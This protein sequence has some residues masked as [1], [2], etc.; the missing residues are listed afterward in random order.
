[1]S[2]F[3]LPTLFIL[4]TSNTLP[5]TGSTADLTAAQFGVFKPDF[6]PATAAN[7]AAQPYVYLAQGR[8]ESLPGVGSK[9][10]DKIYL[11]NVRDWYKMTAH[12]T[13]QVQIT[14]IGNFNILCGETITVSL[15]LTSFYIRTGFFNGLTRSYTVQAPCC[16]CGT[17]PCTELDPTA[18]V[19][20][21]V[22]KIN[23]DVLVSQF[24]FA[25]RT[26]TGTN[27]VLSLVGIPLAKDGTRC[28]PS[29]F[30]YEYDRMD[31]W[32]FCYAGPETTQ[33][34]NVWDNCNQAATVT[35]L[36]RA[37]FLS[38]ESGQ[39][40]QVE[41]NLWSYNQGAQGKELFKWDIFNNANPNTVSYV[42]AG[43]FYDQYYLKFDSPENI[44]WSMGVP[45]DEE[46]LI[47][48]PTGQ[49]AG[50]I[51]VLTAFFGTPVDETGNN[52]TTTTSTSTSTTSTSSTTTIFIP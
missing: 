50:T 11:K 28:D 21:F 45:L 18:L 24:I 52:F 19:D 37:T 3:S 14:T 1:M 29:A 13:A 4:P 36:Q 41:R 22:A 44:N 15:R 35:I 38:G 12:S 32:A 23:A 31:F 2:G 26:G 40:A 25:S 49:N 42:T 33:D 48:N 8:I 46:V 30:P 27:S 16:A 10:S 34:Y 51:A 43:T 5:T 20:E 6:T 9:K 39:V 17:S 7:V 47:F